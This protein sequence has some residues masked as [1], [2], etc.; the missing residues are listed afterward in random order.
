M[1]IGATGELDRSHV[2]VQSGINSQPMSDTALP[3]AAHG[4][5]SFR[6]LL[7]EQTLK[8]TIGMTLLF[9]P[10]KEY[11]DAAPD[12]GAIGALLKEH[13]RWLAASRE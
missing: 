2:T 8:Q 6:E 13:C 9:S 12:S 5:E 4:G 7:R 10:G 11:E 3:H 1:R